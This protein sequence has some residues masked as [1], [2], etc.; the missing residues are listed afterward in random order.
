MWPQPC[1]GCP[2]R[3]GL[4]LLVILPTSVL[5]LGGCTKGLGVIGCV[6]F[7]SLVYTGIG[8]P[9]QGILIVREQATLVPDLGCSWF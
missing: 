1:D 8:D 5:G 7:E 9:H 3:E 4:G 2:S 6:G